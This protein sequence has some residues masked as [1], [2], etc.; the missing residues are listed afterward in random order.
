M[1]PLKVY[2]DLFS[3]YTFRSPLNVDKTAVGVIQL[4][5][6]DSRTGEI[7]YSGWANAPGF[8]GSARYYLQERDLL[9]VAKGVN[10]M[11]FMYEKDQ[12]DYPHVVA[13][14]GFIVIR[15]LAEHLY[16]P[17]LLWYLNLPES[18]LAFKRLQA[19]TT[20]LNLSITA[21]HNFTLKVPPLHKQQSIGDTY[22]LNREHQRLSR[23]R[24][25]KWLQLFNH[26][27]NNLI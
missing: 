27:I 1:T 20:V 5:D 24:D 3:G 4:K 25:E 10:S 9:L 2:C 8:S 12:H 26:Q 11:A 17:Y 14:G 23:E 19:G 21:L 15:P 16:P 6:V 13:S 7:T 18:Q 22:L